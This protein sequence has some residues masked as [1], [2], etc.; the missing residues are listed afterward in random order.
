MKPEKSDV[1]IDMTFGAGGHTR[2][3]L[4]KSKTVKIFC[5]DRDP[6]AYEYAK[7]LQEEYPDQIIPLHGKF[8]DLPALLK[9]HKY[10][11]NSIDGMFF[12]FGTSSMQFD[13]PGR[14]FALSKDGPLDMRM[15]GP[16]SNT[17]TAGEVL[18]Y[19]DEYDLYKIFKIYGDENKARALSKAI[20]ESRYAFRPLKRTS[21]LRDLAA[22]VFGSEIRLDK[23]GRYA[24]SATRVFQA[25]RIFVN[26]ELNE[27]N[28]GMILAAKYL[29]VNGV[30]VTLAFHSLED[31]V[32]KRHVTGNTH[33]NAANQ[34][35]LQF[36]NFN[37]V[38]TEEEMQTLKE[39]NWQPLHKH[40]ITPSEYEVDVNPRSRSAKLRACLKIC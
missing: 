23:L 31:T 18:A 22:L 20:I 38:F 40:V 5:L 24:H 32:V 9:Q 28:H 8:S 39:T 1:I 33:E 27:I 26:N 34:M 7:L 16:G 12:D 4:E 10:G 29:K 14:G 30:M 13:D 37:T 11:F 36:Y 25:L 2:K 17:I 6:I 15:D 21:E 35:P 19:A 3:F